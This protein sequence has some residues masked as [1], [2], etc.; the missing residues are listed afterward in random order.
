MPEVTAKPEKAE[1]LENGPKT[2]TANGPE[3]ANPVHALGKD[4]RGVVFDPKKFR[5]EKDILG[6]WKNIG[7][8]RK[9]G[10]GS[11]PKPAPQAG[12]AGAQP[13]PPPPPAEFGS[14]I[15]PDDATPA[16]ANA[17]N[18]NGPEDRFALA[19]ETYLIAGYSLLDG[20]FAGKG[21]WMPDDE[22]EHRALKQ[23]L[24]HWLRSRQSEDLPPGAAFALAAVGFGAKRFQRPNTRVRWGMWWLWLR[25]KWGD[26]LAQR[27]LRA[28]VDA[29]P[30][31]AAEGS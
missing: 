23:A 26:V 11:S 12:G 22:A 2:E 21:E 18:A 1:I 29:A 25:A 16:P 7:V 28:A 4:S 15:P 3:T 24:A 17:T 20:A 30:I 14:V 6:R 27:K 9:R 5:P 10:T 19:A 31:P 8:G 13:P